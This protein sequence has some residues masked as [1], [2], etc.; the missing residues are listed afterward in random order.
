MVQEESRKEF[1][2]EM[3][4]KFEKARK[5]SLKKGKGELSLEAFLDKEEKACR[6]YQYRDSILD[7]AGD[8]KDCKNRS[9]GKAGVDREKAK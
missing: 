5:K 2:K 6:F 9:C 1:P 3:E 4:K 8:W 7:S